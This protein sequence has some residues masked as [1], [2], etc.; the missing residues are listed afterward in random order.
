MTDM[1][2]LDLPAR[3]LM[4]LLFLVSGYG[5][6]SQNAATQAYMNLHGVPGLLSVPAAAWELVAGLSLLLGLWIRPLAMLLAGWCVLTAV[7]FHTAFADQ[8][9]LMN[10]LKNMTMAGGFLLIA[11]ARPSAFSLDAWR[12]APRPVPP[13]PASTALRGDGSWG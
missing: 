11:R 3:G 7:I 4:S 12:L 13:R 6:L 5:K 10:F 2:F 1:R 8:N 9:Q